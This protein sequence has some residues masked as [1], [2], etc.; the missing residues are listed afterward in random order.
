[1]THHSQRGKRLRI[2]IRLNKMLTV[3]VMTMDYANVIVHFNGSDR[4][5]PIIVI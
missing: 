2:L 5:N 1:M 4:D 3:T